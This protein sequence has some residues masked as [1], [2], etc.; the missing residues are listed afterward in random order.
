MDGQEL[1]QML[2]EERRLRH[3]AEHRCDE[4]R[5]RCKEAEE[6][7]IY[8]QTLQRGL[9][10][11]LEARHPPHSSD[12]GPSRP[13]RISS[14]PASTQASQATTQ[15]EHRELE[16]KDSSEQQN[17]QDR[18]YCTQHCITVLVK[19][20]A[21]DKTCPNYQD[22]KLKLINASEFV[23]LAH[24]QL[25]TYRGN[26]V[27]CAPLDHHVNAWSSSKL[28]K[29]RLSS[30]GYTLV[31]KGT[32]DIQHLEHEHAVYSRLRPVQGKHVP[33]CVGM[34]DLKLPEHETSGFP[35]RFIFLSWGG[36]PFYKC[37][38]QLDESRTRK[39]IMA[40]YS[41][42]HWLDIDP[43]VAARQDILYDEETQK[44]MIIDFKRAMFS[45]Y[46]PLS[47]VSPESQ[48]AQRLWS[49]KCFMKDLDAVISRC[50]ELQRKKILI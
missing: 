19:G 6:R 26:D 32:M 44:F 50:F 28:F 20:G 36:L 25:A 27:D 8:Q 14:T 12:S 24:I 46:K 47:A 9:S 38:T 4:G 41:S 10:Q 42:I 7:Q 39:A 34:T 1:E 11:H 45:E 16:D 37:L 15:I 22:H 13:I 49:E 29:F 21:M 23:R 40:A 31:A 18:P 30:Y 5:R 43:L 35:T 17:I 3:E 48:A 33:V 2:V